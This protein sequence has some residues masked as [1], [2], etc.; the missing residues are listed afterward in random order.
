MVT[1]RARRADEEAAL[2]EDAENKEQEANRAEEEARRAAAKEKAAK[3]VATTKIAGSTLALVLLGAIG[4]GIGVGLGVGLGI[5][6]ASGAPIEPTIEPIESAA[7][8]PAA[9][10]DSLLA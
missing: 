5:K 7:I 4:L 2:V 9:D 10:P 8:E 3:D 1:G 6:W